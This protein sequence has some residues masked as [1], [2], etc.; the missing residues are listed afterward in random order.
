MRRDS[1][2]PAYY[3]KNDLPSPQLSAAEEDLLDF[4][5]QKV[6]AGNS[7]GDIIR[8]LI[9]TVQPLI[10]CDRIGLSFFEE[11]GSRMVL[12]CVV[13]RYEPLFL[14]EGYT[15]DLQGSSLDRVFN[16]GMP[17]VID[18]LEAYATLHPQSESTQL[19]LKEGVMSSMTCP[20]MVDDRPVGLLF[21]SSKTK[22]AYTD[23]ELR[24]HLLIAERLSQ[25]VEKASRIEALSASINAYMEMLSFVSH[26]IKSPLDSIISLGTTLIQG[27]FGEV[28]EKH[29]GYIERMV[30]KAVYLR[31]VSNDYLNLSRFETGNVTLQAAPVDF[32]GAVVNE[33]IDIARPQ[34]EEKKMSIR[35]VTQS[36]ELTVPCDQRLMLVVMNNLVSNAIKYG[37][38][39]TQVTVTAG[40]G[41][42]LFTVSVRNEGPGFT[43]E[44]KKL[45]FKKFSRLP[46][47]A[48]L[49][50]KGSGIGLYICW[51]IMQLH[52]GRISAESEPGKWTEFRIELP[53]D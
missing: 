50:Q 27:Y 17:R 29:R 33:A 20:L 4:I 44:Q 39:G 25:A 48:L 21:F 49:K 23:R 14:D 53:C 52:K 15:A 45:L 1:H 13:A 8:F 12:K 32:I 6:A 26:E 16:A 10:P 38:P 22:N 31:G 34:S 9:D 5:N 11:G 30:Q 24:L 47:E 35:L 36:G 3:A 41:E 51:K 37:N 42:G 2:A 7:L 43:Q 40:V 28:D 46:S 18:N 19:L